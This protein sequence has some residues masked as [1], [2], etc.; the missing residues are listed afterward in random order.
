MADWIRNS[1]KAFW[2]KGGIFMFIRAQFSSQIA[3]IVDF[4]VTILLAKLFRI[5]Y[6]YA[7]FTGSICGGIVNCI[8]NYKWTFRSKDCKKKHVIIKYLLVWGCSILLNTWGI[9]AMTEAIRRNLWVQETLK[10]YTDDIFV[11][12]KV[13]VSLLVGFIWNYNMQRV[14]VYKNCRIRD[15]FPRRHRIKQNDI[16]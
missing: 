6:V 4:L 13:V 11:F 2:E 16:I 10:H 3:S 14:F 8:I 12:S 7:T 1:A 15:R 9:Y 5:Y